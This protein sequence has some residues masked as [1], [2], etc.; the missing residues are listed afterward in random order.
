MTKWTA[1][2]KR[3]LTEGL[4][5]GMSYTAIGNK[6]HV[7]RNAVAGMVFRMKNKKEK[8]PQQIYEVSWDRR[9]FETWEERKRRLARE[10]SQAE[11]V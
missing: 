8:R 9:T 11:S 4:A 10:R 3:V 1:K 2:E 6:L 5:R 7:S